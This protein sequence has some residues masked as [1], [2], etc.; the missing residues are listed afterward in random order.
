MCTNEKIDIAIMVLAVVLLVIIGATYIFI[1]PTLYI[2]FGYV[3]QCIVENPWHK[4]YFFILA[5][6]MSAFIGY[7]IALINDCDKKKN[8]A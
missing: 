8:N 1:V 7:N 6:V 4:T 2:L 5:M 3:S